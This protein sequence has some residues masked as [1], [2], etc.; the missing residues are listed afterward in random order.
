MTKAAITSVAQKGFG[1]CMNVRVSRA[2]GVVA[3]F[4]AWSSADDLRIT[5]RDANANK[6]RVPSFEFV[7]F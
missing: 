7:D 1:A 4:A 6:F 3:E 5:A 2:S